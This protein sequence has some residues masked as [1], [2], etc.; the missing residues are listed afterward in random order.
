M[1][2]STIMTLVFALILVL[3]LVLLPSLI[4]LI[5]RRRR[6]LH[7]HRHRFQSPCPSYAPLTADTEMFGLRGLT[8]FDEERVIGLRVE[9]GMHLGEHEE[10]RGGGEDEEGGG[11]E[12]L[13]VRF[14]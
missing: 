10:G 5:R 3:L 7:R 14:S 2:P 4:A 9:T 11:W 12:R 13:G 1:T 6:L 8:D